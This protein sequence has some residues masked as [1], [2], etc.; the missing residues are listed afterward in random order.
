MTKENGLIIDDEP[1]FR[2]DDWEFALDCIP[3][4]SRQALE[5]HLLHAPEGHPTAVFL[6]AFLTSA[7]TTD[8]LTFTPFFPE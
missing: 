8:G 7:G 4:S 3:I 1:F 2:Q 6:K 5:E